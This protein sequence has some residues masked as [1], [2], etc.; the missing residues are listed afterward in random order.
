MHFAIARVRR[1]IDDV[2]AN[3]FRFAC[4]ACDEFQ[5]RAVLFQRDV[6]ETAV[7]EPA[8]EELLGERPLDRILDEARE[9]P[10]TKRFVISALG[11]PACSLDGDVFKFI[12]DNIESLAEAIE[13]LKILLSLGMAVV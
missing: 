9:R 12:C 10:C 3:E 6:N 2:L 8:E 13:C 7:D 4:R 11:Q 1:A 5:F